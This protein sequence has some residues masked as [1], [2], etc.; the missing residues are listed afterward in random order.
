M[1]QRLTARAVAKPEW[2]STQLEPW[3]PNSSE[4]IGEVWF[5]GPPGSPLLIKFLFTTA[6][7]SVQV[8]PDDAYAQEHHQSRG[9]TEMWHV[10]SAQP[11]ARIAAGFREAVSPERMRAAAESGEIEQ[12]LAWYDAHPG[13][14][15]LI[16]AG[17]VHAIGGGLTLCE[18]QQTSDITYRLYDYGRPRE[19]HLEHGSTVSR[20]TPAEVRCVNREGMLVNC[21]HFTT[22]RKTGPCVIAA[23]DRDQSV[24]VIDG[25]GSVSGESARA[26]DVFLLPAHE[27]AEIQ[28]NLTLLITHP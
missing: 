3:F 11:G 12:L 18:I 17:T 7:L 14:T 10:L 23:L 19:L 4:K 9:K 22:S 20:L 27:S 6:A 28:G 15:F 16:P 21:P 24:I 5:E 1:I 2:G 13:D 8:H 25:A 26:G